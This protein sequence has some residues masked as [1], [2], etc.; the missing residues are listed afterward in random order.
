MRNFL[1][2]LATLV[3]AAAVAAGLAAPARAGTMRDFD[4]ALFRTLQEQDKPVVV[5]V[6]APWCSVCR[7]QSTIIERA[8]G[9]PAYRELTVLKVDFDQQSSIWKSF[10]ADR[11][12]TLIGFRG[13]RET[14]RLVSET[15][16]G[17]VLAVLASTVRT[18]K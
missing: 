8:L 7:A 2:V 15:A 5:Y 4:A 1:L 11:Q 9:T 3:L 13:K 6:H 10:G 14:A 18:V 16:S 12:S 17:K